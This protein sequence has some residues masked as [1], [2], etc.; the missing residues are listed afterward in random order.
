M[1]SK[2]AKL[3]NLAKILP[4]SPLKSPLIHQWGILEGPESPKSLHKLVL[5]ENV[6]NSDFYLVL[7]VEMGSKVAKLQN[8]HKFPCSPLKKPNNLPIG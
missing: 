6:T 2:V 8:G 3:V 5:P 1:G 4:C 7:L